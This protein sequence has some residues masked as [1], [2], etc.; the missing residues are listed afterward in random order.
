MLGLGDQFHPV[1]SISIM[2]P[3]STAPVHETNTRS[4]PSSFTKHPS[5]RWAGTLCTTLN[6]PGCAFKIQLQGGKMFLEIAFRA[7][8]RWDGLQ[9][10][11][12]FVVPRSG[13]F[14]NNDV[15]DMTDC[16]VDEKVLEDVL[17][18]EEVD[19]DE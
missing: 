13:S 9:M 8:P 2:G 19:V 12:Q 17:R 7:I 1:P 10:Y 6:K 11:W 3:P 16:I 4:S 5:I 18:Y 14:A 15:A